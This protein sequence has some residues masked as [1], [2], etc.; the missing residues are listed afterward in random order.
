MLRRG[1][2][3][4]RLDW[5]DRTTLTALVQLL[6]RRLRGHRPVTPGTLLRWH[7]RL[8]ARKW[9][10]PQRQT[11]TTWRQFLH[12]QALTTLAIPGVALFLPL[13]QIASN[14]KALPF[15]V[16]SDSSTGS[17]SARSCLP[18]NSPLAAWAWVPS[19]SIVM[20]VTAYVVRS[21]SQRT[22]ASTVV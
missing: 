12:T 14:Q 1:T 10:A 4:P 16:F 7:R 11:D 9:T 21:F 2:R 15:E 18:V 8:V 20:S 22:L 13:A 17:P 3:R 6:P 19:S 5:A